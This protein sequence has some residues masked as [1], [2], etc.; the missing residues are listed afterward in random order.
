MS[1]QF[2]PQCGAP[3]IEGVQFC[4]SC[5]TELGPSP[6]PVSP[7]A[8]GDEVPPK[9][10][11]RL[12]SGR[13]CL[14]VGILI[15]LVG[16]I[17]GG[18][19]LISAGAL[20]WLKPLE[21]VT[22]D[23]IDQYANGRQVTLT[24]GLTLSE[25]ATCYDEGKHCA[26]EL[27][28]AADATVG[29]GHP[30][31]MFIYFDRSSLVVGPK[32]RLTSGG[33][34]ETGAVVRVTGRVCHTAAEPPETCV[35]V[36]QIESAGGP[37]AEASPETSA[38]TPTPEP[39][40]TPDPEE[41]LVAACYGT[42]VPWAAPY[43]GKTHPLVVVDA[44]LDGIFMSSAINKKWRDSKWTS[45]IQLVVCA[46][47]ATKVSVKVG[48][49]GR[50]WKRTDGV[51]GELLRYRYKSK[52]RVVVAETGKT[53]QSKTLLGS[54]PICGGGKYSSL[55]LDVKPPWKKYGLAVTAKQVNKYATAVSTQKV[56]QP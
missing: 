42:P 39:T 37:I 32:V 45:P 52:I 47:D 21:N 9:A 11:R 12:R 33:S 4:G 14:L 23:T 53:L 43:A 56:K 19:L 18:A 3:V 10:A 5:G 50:H 46:P 49:C 31:K 54:V 28:D 40:A 48:S 16:G 29:A 15:L 13:G 34:V 55:D 17:G 51:V 27:V 7:A 8:G 44:G 35:Y 25:T 24:G 38:P 26:A 20:D 1:A 6:P 30:R 36:E 41:E 22:F 2:C